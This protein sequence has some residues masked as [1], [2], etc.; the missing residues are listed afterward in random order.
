MLFLFGR[1]MPPSLSDYIAQRAPQDGH[2]VVFASMG[3]FPDEEPFAELDFD[4]KGE[5][6]VIFQSVVRAGGFGP[7]SNFMQELACA[8]NLKRE[9]AKAVWG[10]NPFGGFMRQDKIRPDRRESQLSKLSGHLMH[11]AGFDG[12]STVEAHSGLALR[13]YEEG[14]G[15]GNVLNIN[16]NEIFARAIKRMGLEITAVANPDMGADQR[17]ADL[18]ERLGI[19]TRSS[20]DKERDREGT[21]ITGQ[22]GTVAESTVLIDDMASSLGTASKAIEELYKQGS[23]KNHLV[24]SHPIMTGDA[25]TKLAK[26]IKQD[27]LDLVL[28]LPSFAR[29]EEFIRFKQQYGPKIAKKIVFLEEDFNEMIYDHAT[30]VIARHPAMG[31]P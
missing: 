17:A 28:F 21:R 29:D 9:S 6:C 13:N 24:I 1:S 16:P 2:Q 22:H 11:A 15:K 20:F 26:L 12:I 18:A 5:L 30:Q 4:P 19:T 27:K 14:L 7:S 23:K 25:W 31:G 3:E 10:F 8:D